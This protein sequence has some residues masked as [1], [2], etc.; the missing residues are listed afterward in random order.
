MDSWMIIQEK[1]AYLVIIL[2][3]NKLIFNLLLSGSGKCTET[4]D[5]NACS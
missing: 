4:D 1:N 5:E 2:G 3:I